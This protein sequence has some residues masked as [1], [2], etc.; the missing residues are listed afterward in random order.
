MRPT[1]DFRPPGVYAAFIDPARPGLEIADTRTT[2]FVGLTQKGP[3]N[4]PIRIQNWTTRLGTSSSRR[5]GSVPERRRASISRRT[6]CVHA[7]ENLPGDS[8]MRAASA[9]RLRAR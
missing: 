2:G 3:I 5:T 8:R 7:R 4:D 9:V 1:A 6:L